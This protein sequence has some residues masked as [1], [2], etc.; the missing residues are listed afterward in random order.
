VG[1]LKGQVYD[2]VVPNLDK[3]DR[4]GIKMA[5]YSSGS[6]QAQQLLFGNSTEGDLCTYFSAYFDTSV[7]QK[8]DADSYKEILLTLGISAAKSQEALFVTDVLAEAESAHAAGMQVLLAVRPGNA[9][10]TSSHSFRTI[11]TFDAI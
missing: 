3:F 2:D 1:A 8:N 11:T 6:K 7:G 4:S 10:I 9:P 5:V